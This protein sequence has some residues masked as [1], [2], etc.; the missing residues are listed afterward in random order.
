MV[1]SYLD[2][3]EVVHQVLLSDL[4]WKVH[5][6]GRERGFSGQGRLFTDRARMLDSVEARTHTRRHTR[7]ASVIVG[8]ADSRCT[9][10]E[11]TYEH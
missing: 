6:K 10:A 9:L 4:V 7:S 11:L 8:V 2:G 5:I 3:V 1:I